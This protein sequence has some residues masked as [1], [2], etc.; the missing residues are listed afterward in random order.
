LGVLDMGAYTLSSFYTQSAA[1]VFLALT[2]SPSLA[3]E[4]G[5]MVVPDN[6]DDMRGK[7]VVLSAAEREDEE[8]RRG[9]QEEGEEEEEERVPAS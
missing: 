9:E 4:R 5:R 8:D 6:L 2:P 1:L 7:L 3:E